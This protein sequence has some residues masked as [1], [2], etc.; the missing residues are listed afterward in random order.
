MDKES[1]D[2][3]FNEEK[4]GTPEDGIDV[5]IYGNEYNIKTVLDTE[6][7]RKLA[8]FVD[9]KMWNIAET[10]KLA[11]TTKIAIMTALHIAHELFQLKS[12]FDSEKK[13]VTEKT[14]NIIS[15]IDKY[16]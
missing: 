3:D 12:Q 5:T 2:F 8:M 9:K 10:N 14:K 4:K 7:A 16:S 6:H 11:S 15:L 1:L 13:V